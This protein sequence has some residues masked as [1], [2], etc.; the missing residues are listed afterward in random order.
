[1][2]I[3]CLLLL[4]H[5]TT[6]DVRGQGN[7]LSIKNPTTHPA[8][9]HSDSRGSY[10]TEPRRAEFPAKLRPSCHQ[11]ESPHFTLSSFLPI[12]PPWL[13]PFSFQRG[14]LFSK[15]NVLWVAEMR[16]IVIRESIITLLL[17]LSLKLT[18]ASL[19]ICLSCSMTIS[20]CLPA[21]SLSSVSLPASHSAPG[22]RY[23][24]T[25]LCGQPRCVSCLKVCS[26]P[27]FL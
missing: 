25:W 27:G 8:L 14:D 10:Y 13:P 22:P 23:P 6:V 21:H 17:L 26:S 16:L 24:A 9:D 20:L 15:R 1:M 11:T 3:Y 5:F 7:C 4:Q 19:P 12:C 2:C 18:T